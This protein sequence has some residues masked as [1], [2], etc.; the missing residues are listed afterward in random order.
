ME[1]RLNVVHDLLL[2]K[3][4]GL[5]RNL[6]RRTIRDVI[7]DKI[8]ALI[9]SGLLSVGDELPGKES[10]RRHFLSAVKLC[11]AP[12]RFWRRVEFLR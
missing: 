11:V 9:A 8:S 5:G 12:S 1:S 2:D 3:S 4:A 7:A 6:E 10:W